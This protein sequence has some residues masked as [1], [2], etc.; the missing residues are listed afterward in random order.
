M[1]L[2]LGEYLDARPSGAP[3]APPTS[4]LPGAPGVV[5]AK[6][7]TLKSSA[8]EPGGEFEVELTLTIKDNYHLYANPAGSEDVIPTVVALAPGSDATLVEVRY[9]VGESKILAANGPG[10]ISVYEKRAIATARIR[11]PEDARL[12]AATVKLQVRYQACDDRSCQA[13]ATLDVPV[14]VEVKGR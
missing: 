5:S 13:P 12:G 11:L 3:D 4:P 10:R 7:R 14:V 8:V 9:P 6:A 1:L 2:A